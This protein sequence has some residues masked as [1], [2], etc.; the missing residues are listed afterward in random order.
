MGS[1]DRNPFAAL[2]LGRHAKEVVAATVGDL[3][4][5]HA[6][7]ATSPDPTRIVESSALSEMQVEWN[8]NSL[9]IVVEC[10]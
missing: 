3:V 2:S 7:C 9:S 5:Q 1:K 6:I 10:P 8:E 4:S